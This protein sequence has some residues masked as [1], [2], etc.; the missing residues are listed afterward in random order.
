ML[1]DILLWVLAS[2]LYLSGCHLMYNLIKINKSTLNTVSKLKEVDPKSVIFISTLIWPIIVIGAG[3]T[4][5]IKNN[6]TIKV[7]EDN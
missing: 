4:K 3:I 1:L 5:I 6:A 2:I 7:E